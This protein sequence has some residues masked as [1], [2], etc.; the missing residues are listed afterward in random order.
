MDGGGGIIPS[1]LEAIARLRLDV[2][3]HRFVFQIVEDI[4]IAIEHDAARRSQ[5]CRAARP[6]ERLETVA[7]LSLPND[8]LPALEVERRFLRVGKLPIILIVIAATG[9]RHAR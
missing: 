8:R 5:N 9:G 1:E 2:L 4:P 6:A 7:A 3:F